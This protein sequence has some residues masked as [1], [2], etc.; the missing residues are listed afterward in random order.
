LLVEVLSKEE[1]DSYSMDERERTFGIDALIGRGQ[2]D[3]K[4]T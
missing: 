3:T 4:K 2:K 1:H